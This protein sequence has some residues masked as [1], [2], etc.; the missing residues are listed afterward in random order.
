MTMSVYAKLL[1][2]QF[3][4]KA[5]NPDVSSASLNMKAPS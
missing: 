5:L 4:G 3:P 1:Q 2:L